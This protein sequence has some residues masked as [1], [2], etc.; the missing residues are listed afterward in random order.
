MR[1]PIPAGTVLQD[2]YRI[3]SVLGQ[4]GFGRTYLAEDQGRFSELCALKELT[5]ADTGAYALEKSKELFQREAQIL[6]QIQ[7]PQIPQFRATFEYEQRLF[8]VQ[9]YVEGQTY[10][11]LLDQRRS[12]GYAFSEAE[13]KQ[14]FL[15]LLPVLA[16]IHSKGIIHRDITPDNIIL[17]AQDH[18]PVL[19]D[20][21]VVKELATK[22]QSPVSLL[23][24]ATALQNTTVGKLG[25]APIEQIQTGRAYSSSDLYSLAVTAVVLLTGRE[26]QELLDDATMTWYWQRWVR[27]DPG[28][29]QVISRM[30][31]YRPGDRYQS[32]IDVLEAMQF[33]PPTVQPQTVPPVYQPAAYQSPPDSRVPTMAVGREPVQDSLLASRPE[34]VIERTRSSIWDDPLAVTAIGIGMVMLTG[35]GSWAIV[36]AVLNPSSPNPVP[37]ETQTI[38]PSPSATATFTPKPPSPKPTPEPATYSQRLDIA[39]DTRLVQNGTLGANETINYIV[40]AQQGQQLSVA[41]GGEGVLMTVL[42][43]N[44]QPLSQDSQRVSYWQGT[45]PYS[46]DYYI[47]LK[48][49]KG[50]DRSD[51]RLDVNLKNTPQ[52]SPDPTF[53]P[54]PSPTID[55][56]RVQFPSGTT[57]TTVS[58]QSNPSVTK[59][60]LV[61][62]RRGQILS[63]RVLNGSVTLNI[64]YPGGRLVE[65][66]ANVLS[67]ESELPR[68]GDYKID[69]IATQDTNFQLDV[70]VRDL[71]QQ[72]DQGTGNTGGGWLG[73]WVNGW[74]G[75]GN[76]S[77]RNA[78]NGWD[79]NRNSGRWS[80]TDSGRWPNKD[81]NS[82][83]QPDKDRDSGHWPDRG[84]NSTGQTGRDR[85]SGRWTDRNRDSNGQPNR[86]RTSDRWSDRNRDSGSSNGQNNGDHGRWADRSGETGQTNRD[87]TSGRWPDRNRDSG[88]SNGQN[89][90]DRGR[91]ADGDLG[92]QDQR[93]PSEPNTSSL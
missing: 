7:H 56:Q 90:G 35:I 63:V 40:S 30:L 64:R 51:Y 83:G 39:P 9:D 37:T 49:V 38:T 69:V 85:S 54:S 41:I 92:K 18:L 6:Y 22:F 14:L 19:I 17:R 93:K 79:R 80:D 53:S 10:R 47:Q 89:N 34:P 33:P 74:F 42:G 45:L 59:R 12:Q 81:R 77:G 67:W 57:G 91:W 24:N 70:N 68:G 13:V 29:A 60:Y 44:R 46:G 36:R 87:R 88:S 31:S 86:D 78:G 73:K 71:A 21:G 75:R 62:A 72:G 3:L 43:P 4:G 76:D 2:R 84:K 66:A 27:V 8:L 11:K 26:P 58:D 32:A 16:Y 15:Q 61:N 55:T 48:P 82:N 5:P 25:Y 20:F 23:P 52:P 50:L 28:F 65:G 1:P